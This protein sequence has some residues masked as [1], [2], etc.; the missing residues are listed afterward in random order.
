MNR[1][2]LFLMP[3]LLAA[4]GAGE[5]VGV[6]AVQAKAAADEAKAGKQLEDQTKQQVEQALAAD[7]N[8]LDAADA[9]NR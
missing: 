7:K 1:A 9:G 4:C 5:S 2:L 6:A 3:F 8:N